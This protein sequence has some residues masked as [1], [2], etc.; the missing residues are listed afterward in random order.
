MGSAYNTP[1]CTLEGVIILQL[2]IIWNKSYRS[3]DA[4]GLVSRIKSFLQ[5]DIKAQK[6]MNLY[7]IT[8]DMDRNK[9]FYKMQKFT[10]DGLFLAVHWAA[11]RA[12]PK[13]Y[14]Y[15]F[16]VPSPF[17]C[18]FKDQPHHSLDNVFIWGLLKELL[19][20]HQ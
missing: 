6:M 7:Q 4:A 15:R 10:A 12:N 2:Y 13:I 9:T 16:D 11:L 20:P 5:D 8:A 18:D 14:A 19:P 3:F 17:E 1:D